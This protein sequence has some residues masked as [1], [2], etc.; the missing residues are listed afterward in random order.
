MMAMILSMCFIMTKGNVVAAEETVDDKVVKVSFV[1]NGHGTQIAPI[2]LKYGDIINDSLDPVDAEGEYIFGG[3]YTDKDFNNYYG[4]AQ[5]KKDTTLYA[6]WLEKISVVEILGFSR[7]YAGMEISVDGIH[8]DDERWGFQYGSPEWYQSDKPNGYESYYD[9]ITTDTF[10]EGRIYQLHIDILPKSGYAFAPKGEFKVNV[11]GEEPRILYVSKG[12]ASIVLTYTC[13]V[14]KPFLP[15][16]TIKGKTDTVDMAVGQNVVL[17]TSVTDGEPPY[18]YQYLMRTSADGKDMVLKDYTSSDTYTGP[19]K[20]VGTKI[21]TVNVKDSTGA[22]VKSNSVTVNVARYAELKAELLGNGV[23]GVIYAKKGQSIFLKTTAEGGS[24]NY[25]YRYEMRNPIKGTTY[26][27]KDYSSATS[28]TAPLVCTG[29]KEF[30]VKVKDSR[31]VVVSSN[32]VNVVV[33]WMSAGL[34]VNNQTG[35]INLAKGDS[36]NLI[37]SVTGGS[38]K[39]TYQYVMKNVSTG[40]TIVLKDYSSSASYTGPLVSAGTKKFIINVK[41]SE[42]E[43]TA[44]N[45]VTVV[46]K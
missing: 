27:L 30:T 2:T 25:Q 5:I 10:V 39:Y 14:F 33:P 9:K 34:K 18:K 21:F 46:V 26:V 32:S 20:V 35:T 24:G 6:R 16:L 38:G 17:N 4:H 40:Q 45:V 13:E 42:G 29:P 3:W 36:V 11:K 28:Y 44:T 1:M 41:D 37:P 12:T 22:V 43:T 19:L 15:E 8:T 31:G 7:P 23:N